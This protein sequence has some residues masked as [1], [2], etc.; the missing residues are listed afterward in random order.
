MTRYAIDL[1][2][3]DTPVKVRDLTPGTELRS[4]SGLFD[5]VTLE[6]VSSD[7]VQGGARVYHLTYS[8]GTTSSYVGADELRY[9]PTGG[10]RVDLDADE[11]EAEEGRTLEAQLDAY[12]E[13]LDECYP[14]TPFNISAS[15]ILRECDPIAYRVGF[16]DWLDSEEE[17][18]ADGDDT[19][20][21][22]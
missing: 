15:R 22:G 13:M 4:F 20:L 12:E 1:Q 8:D 7:V 18:Q 16:H 3:G 9:L 14:D 21:D 2:E 11:D 5:T 10:P 17:E 19:R 6:A